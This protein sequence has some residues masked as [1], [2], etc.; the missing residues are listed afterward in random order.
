MAF[1]LV[2]ILEKIEALYQLPRN[3]ERFSI[4][5]SLL[6]G[7][8]GKDMVLPISAYNP[9]AKE[10]ALLKLQKLKNLEAEAIASNVI[11][12]INQKLS[13]KSEHRI[14]VVI[15]LADDMGG[16]WSSRYTTDYTSK[17]DFGPILKRGFCTPYFWT[18]ED[19]THNTIRERVTKSILRTLYWLEHGKP[20]TLEDHIHQESSIS[21][22]R[23]SQMEFSLKNTSIDQ[24]FD[25]H[26][27]SEDYGLIFNFLYGDEASEELNYT[28]HGIPFLGGFNY[29]HYLVQKGIGEKFRVDYQSLLRKPL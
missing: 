1:R 19:Y 26:K 10:D 22:K 29:A 20:K 14:S 28:A 13:Q 24:F 9:M 15:N 17:F 23:K 4:Y 12:E 21:L 2:P 6:Q 25:E 5:L 7:K 3:R 11:S 16:S 18:S 8:E 27:H